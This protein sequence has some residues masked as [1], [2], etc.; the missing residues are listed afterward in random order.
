MGAERENPLKT[1][2]FAFA[3]CVVGAY[4]YL[5]QEHHEYVLSKQLLRSGTS[6][7][8]NITEANQAQSRPD[9]I[10]KLSIA[11]KEVVETDYWICLLRDSDYL[12]AT[13]ADSLIEDC[14]E[15]KKMLT[16][17]IKSAKRS[18]S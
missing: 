6:V 15:I 3:L 17:A 14:T 18:T 4:K 12:S 9:F 5:L 8:A 2:S 10:H 11:L 13:Q 16:S 1:K 7:G